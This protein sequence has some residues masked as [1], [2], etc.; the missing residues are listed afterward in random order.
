MA[1]RVASTSTTSPSHNVDS[2]M[3]AYLSLLSD[4]SS[5][6]CNTQNSLMFWVERQGTFPLLAPLAQDLLSSPASEAYVKRDFSVCGDLTSGKR[7]RL[8]KNLETRKFLKMNKKY[9]DI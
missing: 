2:E 3:A 1:I 9:Y 5:S 7:N 4:T 6:S 8:T